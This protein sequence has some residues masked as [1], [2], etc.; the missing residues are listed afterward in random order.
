MR[1]PGVWPASSWD[2]S[3]DE[4]VLAEFDH[5]PI[6]DEHCVMTMWHDHQPLAKV[7]WV[8]AY[9]AG[10]DE[11]EFAATLLLHVAPQ[12]NKEA[13]LAAYRAAVAGESS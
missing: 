3:I 13:T 6:P 11:V 4:A 1:S 7:F 10:L 2:D 9:A 8:S 5:G 12:A